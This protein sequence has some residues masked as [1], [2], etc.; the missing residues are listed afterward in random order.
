MDFEKARKNMV[1]Y[2][3][4]LRGIYD[5]KILNAFMKVKRHLFV[6]ESIQE[7]AYEDCALPIGEGQTISQPYI[8]ALMLQ[9]LELNENDVV[10]E[11][12]TGSGYQ[13]ALLANIVKFVYSIERNEILMQKAKERLLN[14]GYNN[15][16][17]EIGD[18][19]KGW[20]E[21]NISFDK[22]IVSAAA[23]KVPEPLFEQL[24]S[25][26]VM[27]IPIGSKTYQ[28]LCK[29]VKL[30]DGSMQSEDYD[31]CVFVPLIGEYG[32]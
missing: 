14:L 1:E 10:L 31:G 7:Y 3:L 28:R 22:I 17:I 27:V 16:F 9:I 21:K 12:G 5:K 20:P 4:K 11:V 8:I 24:K 32:W 15:I 18:G 29:I 25:T 30:N 23:P 13:T 19:T 6:P 26:G 2:Q